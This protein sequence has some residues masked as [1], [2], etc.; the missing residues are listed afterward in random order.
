MADV[1][2]KRIDDMETL[3]HGVARRARAELG[4][5]AW[6]M[7]VYELPPHWDGHPDHAHDAGTEEA[8]GGA[9]VVS[10]RGAG[11]A[12]RAAGAE[13][14]D[15][16]PGTMVRVGPAQHRR[17]LPGPDGVRYLAIGGVV[18]AHTPSPW[19]ELGGP[20]PTPPSV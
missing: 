13:R 14:F 5:T 18:G 6:G 12:P 1:T 2:Y 8:A 16:R 10:V 4:I 11:A 7:Q 20:W 19:T 15:L 3:Y 17:I 9:G